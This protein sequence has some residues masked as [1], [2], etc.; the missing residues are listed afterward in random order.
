MNLLVGLSVS[1]ISTLMKTGKRDQLRSQIELISYVLKFRCTKLFQLMTRWGCLKCFP[2]YIQTWF[3]N[4][5]DKVTVHHSDPK[6]IRYPAAL[7]KLLFK[8]CLEMEKESEETEMKVIRKSLRERDE[9]SIIQNE[10]SMLRKTL[11]EKEER[12]KQVIQELNNIRKI[13]PKSV[14]ISSL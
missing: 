7:K 10:F 4:D 11:A 14:K 9:L 5:V 8:H 6:D 1:D 3:G 12:E 2:I 13:L